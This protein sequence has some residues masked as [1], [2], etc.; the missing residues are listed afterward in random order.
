MESG[1]KA[2]R[3]QIFSLVSIFPEII[4]QNKFSIFIIHILWRSLFPDTKHLND[5]LLFQ[6]FCKNQKIAIALRVLSSRWL[7]ITNTKIKWQNN[8]AQ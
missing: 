4:F 7:A 8:L 2:I 6:I 5:L 1:D 3:S